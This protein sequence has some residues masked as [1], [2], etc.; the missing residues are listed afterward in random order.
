MAETKVTINGETDAGG[1]WVAWTPTLTGWSANPTGGNYYYYEVGKMITLSISQPNAGTSNATTCVISLP[2]T[3]VTRAG[4]Q[5]SAPAK[6]IDNAVAKTSPGLA[7]IGTGGT[8]C[9]VTL[10]YGFNA[11]TASGNKRIESCT[12]TY[13]AA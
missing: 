2:F 10:D 9:V 6:I 7:Q 4:A 3:A 1:A 11:F 5:W 8:T 12:I 13:E